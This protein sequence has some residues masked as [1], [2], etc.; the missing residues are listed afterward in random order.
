MAETTFTLWRQ[1]LG[2]GIADLSCNLVWQMISLYLMFFYTDVMGLPAY[3]VGLMFLVTRLVDG[4]ADVLM[5]LVIDNTATR[6]GR[7]RPYLLIGAIPFGLL[8]ILAFYVPD[9][10]TTGKLI[11]AFVTYLCLSFLYTIVNIPFC[12][13]L[14]V[15]DERLAGTHHAV[16]GAYSARLARRD[17]RR[18]R[19]FAAGWRAGERQ[20]AARLLL[21]GGGFR[22]YCHL[23]PAGELPER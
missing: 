18:G 11:Y 7:C 17:H 12:A 15:S 22:R 23:L 19:H 2:Y 20:S 8:C 21:Y 4:V 6:W 1:R 16:G 5:G 13:M 10:G 14:A 9:F 3:Y